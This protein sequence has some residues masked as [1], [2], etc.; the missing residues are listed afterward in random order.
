MKL[1]PSKD[2]FAD[3]T[4]RIASTKKGNRIALMSMGFNPAE[5]PVEHLLRE[6]VA[7]A[8][9]GVSV[10]LNI[11]AHSFMVDDIN[12]LPLGPVILHRDFRGS[13]RQHCQHKLA[14]LDKLTASGGKWQILNMPQSRF[15][16]PYGGRSHI[17]YTVIN[18]TVYLGGCNLNH[19][20]NADTMLRLN[21]TATADW[22]YDVILQAA[23][24]GNVRRALDGRDISL[25]IDSDTTL[26]IDAG[27]K[28]QSLIYDQAL[29]LIDSAE[30]HLTMTCQFFPNK[31]T[32]R[33][34][35]GAVR[36]GVDV[37]LYFNNP[38][39]QNNIKPLAMQF[40]QWREQLRCPPELFHWQLS[41]EHPFLHAKLLASEKAAMIGSHNY[42]VQGIKFGT[43]ETALLSQ[44]KNFARKLSEV[45][46]KLA[47]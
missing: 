13:R 18:D 12:D 34:L 31:T 4:R 29:Q 19:T 23:K 2:Y 44:D 7:A 47:N 21:D 15:T 20:G 42:V 17:K 1:L 28:H 3:I 26:F 43:A 35:H 41:K 38:R 10:Q 16:N 14:W 8:G 24:T 37:R 27:V 25:A 9:R 39:Q 36:R 32:A 46:E 22:I 30:T 5:A 6:V 45:A 11:D 40:V 33:H